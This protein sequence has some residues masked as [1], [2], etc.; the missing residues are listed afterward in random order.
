MIRATPPVPLRGYAICAEPDC[1]TLARDSTRE[2]VRQH[3]GR[4]HHTVRFVVE[5]VTYYRFGN[6]S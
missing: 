3:V 6:A 2:R 1:T 5:T 4:T